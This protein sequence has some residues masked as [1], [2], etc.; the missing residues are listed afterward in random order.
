M[1]YIKHNAIVVTHWQ[2]EKMEEAREKAIEI[3]GGT[4]KD[5][6][7][8]RDGKCLISELMEGVT[9]GQFTFFLAPDG[10]KEGWATSKNGDTA[11]QAF[12]NWLRDADNY[13]D[14]IEVQFGGDDDS[15][16]I[17]RSKHSDFEKEENL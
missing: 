1:G 4:F 8:V 17:V 3:F 11:R 14:Y 9:N 7:G 6:W 5:E 13:V 16:Y 10:S 15:E 12:L 2:K